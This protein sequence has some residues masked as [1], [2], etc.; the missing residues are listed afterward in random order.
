MHIL[1]ADHPRIQATG[2]QENRQLNQSLK[3]GDLLKVEIIDSLQKQLRLLL[4]DGTVFEAKLDKAIDVYIGQQI[5]LEVKDIVGRQISM[6][7]SLGEHGDKQ[8]DTNMGMKNILGQLDVAVTQESEEAVKVLMQKMLPIT[9]ENIRQIEFGLKTSQLPIGTLLSM[10]ENEIPVTKTNLT[11]MQ[12]YKNGEIKLQAQIQ[13]IIQDILLDDNTE[14]LE[15]VHTILSDAKKE[16]EAHAK[17]PG[18]LDQLKPSPDKTSINKGTVETQEMIL[19]NATLEGRESSVISTGSKAGSK[20]EPFEMGAPQNINTLKKEISDIF[21][22][23]F[24]IR[25]EQ[26]KD[27]T[28]TKL[29]NTSKLY[30]EIYEV[31]DALEKTET[32]S[33]QK[34]EAKVYADV[35]SNIEFLNIA[36]K[37]DTMIHIPL[38]IQKQL[39]HGELYI[40]NQKKHSKKNYHEASMLISLETVYLGA[41]EAYVKKYNKQISCQFKTDDES[42]EKI[43]KSSIYLLKENL[44]NKGYDLATVSYIPSSQAFT[45]KEDVR[46]EMPSGRY[47]FDTK[48]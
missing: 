16:I 5:I 39:K 12:A 45:T 18:L 26:L 40:F 21:K 37:Y 1:S 31:V 15:T 2:T 47:R 29:R 27:N 33:P 41:I 38:V 11:Q 42:I 14:R 44:K 24:F 28:D 35:K 13:T 30:K 34:Q 7:I 25:P 10:L 9:K 6:E 32:Q 23:L 17:E 36:S 3:I 8:P 20:G 22:E 19:K 4:A 43:I 46:G 48:V